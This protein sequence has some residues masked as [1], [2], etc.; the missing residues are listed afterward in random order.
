MRRARRAVV[1]MA[2]VMAL[3]APARG[4]KIVLKNGRQ[5]V[6]YHVVEDGDRVRYETSAGE[7]SIPKSIV[8]HI[9]KSGLLPMKQSPAEAAANIPPPAMETSGDRSGIDEAAV[10]DGEIDLN[11]IWRLDVE[12]RK[13]GKQANER[14][15]LAHHDAAQF[16][17]SQGDLEHALGDERTALNYVPDQPVLMV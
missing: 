6:A 5:I 8:D 4:D 7:L 9:E 1:L 10:H 15:A 3:A 17:L 12:A 16:E 13:G 14:A 11:Y 2:V